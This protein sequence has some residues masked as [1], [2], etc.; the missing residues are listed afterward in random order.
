MSAGVS[1]EKNFIVV[2][3]ARSRMVSGPERTPTK[4]DLKINFWIYF[5]SGFLP[6][7]F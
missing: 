5:T 3:V 2:S 6:S 4:V 7:P 1:W